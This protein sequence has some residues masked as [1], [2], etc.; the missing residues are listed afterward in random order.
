MSKK[1]IF[2]NLMTDSPAVA[3]IEKVTSTPVAKE[4]RK[5]PGRPPK[6]EKEL[7]QSTTIRLDPDDHLAVRQLAL[8]DKQTMNELIFIALKK[9]CDGRGVR[10]SGK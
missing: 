6:A 7:V 9:Y 4:E 3:V 5:G 1:N 10:L 8:R 2:E